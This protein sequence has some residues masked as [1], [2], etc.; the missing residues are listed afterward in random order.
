MVDEQKTNAI[1]MALRVEG[2]YWNAYLARNHTMD[3]AMLLGSILLGVIAKS[4]DR[5][6]RF[7]ALMQEALT[8]A[9]KDVHGLQLSWPEPPRPAP[10]HERSGTA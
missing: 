8:D 5:K 7:M 6:E 4:P 1:R 10:E 3:G 2:D 9:A